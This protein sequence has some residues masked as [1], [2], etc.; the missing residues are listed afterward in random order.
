MAAVC[1]LT[2]LLATSCGG[3]SSTTP[4]EPA[5]GSVIGTTPTATADLQ[6]IADRLSAVLALGY[7]TYTTEDVMRRLTGLSGDPLFV[8]DIRDAADYAAGHIPGAINIPIQDLPRALLDGTHGI[9]SD[10]DVCVASYW[11]NDGTMA[12]LLLNV[13]RVEDPAN[14]GSY[15]QAKA[16][17]QGMTSWTFDRSLVPTGT[18]FDDAMAAGVIVSESTESTANPGADQGAFPEFAPFTVTPVVERILRRA[19]LYLNTVPDAGALQMHPSDLQSLLND[20]N[21]ANDPQIVS[22]RSEAHYALGHVPGAVNVPYKS[23]AD[24][25]N[26]TKFLAPGEPVV[27]YCY[28]GHTGGIATMTF[29]ILGYDV[30]NLLYGMNGWS[31]TAPASGQ[32]SNFDVNRGWDFPLH[33]T[34]GGLATLDG[35]VPPSTGCEGCHTNLTSLWYSLEIDPLPGTSEPPS[36]GEG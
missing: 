16:L 2:L 21:G 25:A 10:T 36:S 15:K 22:V 3:G 12:A 28:T 34:D 31:Q 19:E 6:D 20:G 27:V 24:L 18:R 4:S 5:S 7:N 1:V 8:V 9:P 11:G 33:T 29:G 17:F 13:F 35:Y 30:V 14:A 26:Y 23:A 32:L